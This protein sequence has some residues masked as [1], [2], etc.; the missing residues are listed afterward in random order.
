MENIRTQITK[1]CKEHSN[2][3]IQSPGL[4]NGPLNMMA[5]LQALA[6]IESS[7]GLNNKSRFEKAYAPGG[8][9][10]K[11]SQL[12]QDVYN[13]ADVGDRQG[14][15][16]SWGPW[17]IMY[18]VAY[19]MGYRGRPSELTYPE[20][21]IKYVVKF[22]NARIL[23]KNPT[24]LEAIFDSYN[25]GNFKDKVIPQAYIKKGMLAY[26]KYADPD[27]P[28]VV[29]SLVLNAGNTPDVNDVHEDYQDPKTVNWWTRFMNV[30]KRRK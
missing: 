26:A 10:F 18:I 15:A 27:D 14:I 4:E 16:S 9:L 30:F 29:N 12:L 13:Q 6:E 23:K 20:K 5:L 2:Y 19:E 8:S 24:L 3:L 21:V 17:Q 1:Q 28:H 7:Y 25:S 22:L 11:R